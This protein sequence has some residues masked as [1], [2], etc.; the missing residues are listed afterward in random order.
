LQEK[1]IQS[2][3]GYFVFTKQIMSLKQLVSHVSQ[4]LVDRQMLCLKDC[5]IPT[6]QGLK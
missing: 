5:E 4:R 3:W 2:S 1:C 6:V